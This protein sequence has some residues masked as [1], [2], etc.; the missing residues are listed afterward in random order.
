MIILV[1]MVY[2]KDS[3]TILEVIKKY[4]KEG[5]SLSLNDVDNLEELITKET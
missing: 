4:V 2:S 1:F 3:I 5:P